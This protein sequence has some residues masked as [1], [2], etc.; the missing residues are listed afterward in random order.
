MTTVS[1][2]EALSF[3]KRLESI[4]SVYERGPIIL[5]LFTHSNWG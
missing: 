2:I 5:T 4:V 3:L 1:A